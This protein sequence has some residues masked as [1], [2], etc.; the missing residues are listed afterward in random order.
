MTRALFLLALILLQAPYRV[1]LPFV[2]APPP[3]KGVAGSATPEQM[4][5]VQA[6]WGHHW[7]L[8]TEN[9]PLG[10]VDASKG[11]WA[12]DEYGE[13]PEEIAAA[14]QDCKS[15]WFMV[16]DEWELQGKPLQE[17]VEEARW[18]IQKRDEVNPD[19]KL[20]FGG[21]LTF[22]PSVGLIAADWAPRF[23]EAYGEI[24]DVQAVVLDD[25]YWDYWHLIYGL[26][27]EEIT[28][29]S[30]AAV[31]ESFGDVQVW[32]RE[33][34]CLMSHRC[35]LDAVGML[36]EITQHYDRWAW[37]ISQGAGWDY[38]ALWVDGELTDLGEMYAD[39]EYMGW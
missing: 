39:Y 20:A 18:Y 37:F 1:Y 35:A 34:G 6:T 17:Q 5:E 33:I 13:G 2:V 36:S 15:G 8:R 29:L 24:P 23:V 21:I 14:M 27:W 25:Y 31:K 32:D 12:W 30:V 16:G 11:F 3:A 9:D 26:S 4:R 7:T 28:V 38:T 10:T 22:H 19:C